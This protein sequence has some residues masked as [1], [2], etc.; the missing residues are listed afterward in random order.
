MCRKVVKN[1]KFYKGFKIKD[2]RLKY[3]CL[4]LKLKTY[5]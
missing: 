3:T 2:L 4:G 1:I 5:L